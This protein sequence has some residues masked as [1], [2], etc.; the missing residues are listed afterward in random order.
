M[1]I[2]RT[3]YAVQV[4]PADNMIGESLI[5]EYNAGGKHWLEKVQHQNS[6]P[7]KDKSA[8]SPKSRGRGNLHAWQ[9]SAAASQQELHDGVNE[10]MSETQQNSA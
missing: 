10:S 8:D 4:I 6:R 9:H 3:A 2:S 7:R 5:T 1:H